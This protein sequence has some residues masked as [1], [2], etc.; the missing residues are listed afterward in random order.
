MARFKRKARAVYARARS[1]FKRRSSRRHSSGG[2]SS[3][4]LMTVALPA[5]AYGAVRNTAKGYISP[6]S[7][8]LPFGDN[9]DEV[10]MGVAGWALHKY[11]TGFTRDLGRTMLTVEIAS[12]GHNIVNP[13][14]AGTSIQ[15]T[16]LAYNY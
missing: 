13:M 12:L 7:N 6:I 2:S 9:N 3:N 16:N 10:V 1:A 14:L 4:L 8:F 11:T 15:P 5:F